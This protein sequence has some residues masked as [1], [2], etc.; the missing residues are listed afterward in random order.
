MRGNGTA[1][2]WS[3]SSVDRGQWIQVDLGAITGI[4]GIATQ[5]RADAAQWVTRYKVSHSYDG[6]YFVFY[7]KAKNNNL[8]KVRCERKLNV[9]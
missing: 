9:L 7:H 2:A 4:T 1:G 3:P 8:D 6:G 5:G